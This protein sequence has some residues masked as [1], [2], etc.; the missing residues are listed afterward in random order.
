MIV[1]TFGMLGGAVFV[2]ATA[3]CGSTA[4]VNET[5]LG[6]AF[7][8]KETVEKHLAVAGVSGE[9]LR[10]DDKGTSWEVTLATE[11]TKSSDAKLERDGNVLMNDPIRTLSVNKSDGKVSENSK[12][13]R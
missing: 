6:N 10:L 2:I 9:V 4:T 8:E 12:G 7:G 13:I 11:V 1:R 5:T 3:G